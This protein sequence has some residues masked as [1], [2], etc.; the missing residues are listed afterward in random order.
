[1][2]FYDNDNSDEPQVE[3]QL[4]GYCNYDKSEIYEGDDVVYHNGKM[5]HRL[6]FLQCCTGL[7]G[8]FINPEE[9]EE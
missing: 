1:M 7:D 4:L 2:G 9:S 3:K 6:N 5:Y 8:E